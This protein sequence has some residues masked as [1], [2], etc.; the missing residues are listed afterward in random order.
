MKKISIKNIGPL[1]EIELDLN[2]INIFI[3][4]Q[5]SGKSTVAKLISFCN[6]LEK[7]CIFNQSITIVNKDYIYKHLFNYYNLDRYLNEKWEL[8]YE[9][10]SLFLKLSEEETK[11][12]RKEG[13]VDIS[14]SKNIY[15]PSERNM[16]AIPEIFSLKMSQN[17][18]SEFI[19]D[20]IEIRSHYSSDHSI[21]IPDVSVSYYFEEKNS[22]DYIKTK[23]SKT[24]FFSQASSGLQ[25]IIPLCV[26]M[27]YITSWVYKN[28]EKRSAEKRQKYRRGF[29]KRFLLEV[30]TKVGED[31][32]K[33]IISLPNEDIEFLKLGILEKL[34]NVKNNDKSPNFSEDQQSLFTIL[35][36]TDNFLNRLSHPSFSN[37]V[38]EEPEQNIFPS[39]QVQLVYYILSKLEH[40]KRQDSLVITTHSPY[41]LYAINNCMLAYFVKQQDEMDI[42]ELTEIPEDSFVNPKIVSVWELKDGNIINNSTIQ[43]EKGLIRNNFFD[44]VM[45]NVMA[46]FKNL[47]GV[48]NND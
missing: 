46:D 18:L 39:T 45:H 48:W 10:D 17:Y 40:R 14:L 31:N 19:D 3:G 27:D 25:S 9:S 7:D 26:I 37:L 6:W 32:F 47:L 33:K 20:W 29:Q 2:R 35:E 36:T 22:R 41:I 11:I 1:K 28:E 23:N 42:K 8:K 21:K 12:Y 16:L 13:F 5:C 43:D 44:K 4:P 15:L 24:L 30:I 38:I 34:N